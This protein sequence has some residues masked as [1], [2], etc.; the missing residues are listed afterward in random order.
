MLGHSTAYLSIVS[1]LL[2]SS[3]F[4]QT[5]LESE[6]FIDLPKDCNLSRYYGMTGKS[7]KLKLKIKR[8]LFTHTDYI[9][10]TF[11]GFSCGLPRVLRSIQD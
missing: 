2:A 10:N 7:L 4:A 11:C 5:K 3:S 1:A 6:T 8:N 9:T